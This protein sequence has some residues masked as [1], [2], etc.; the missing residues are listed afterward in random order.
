MKTAKTETH[1]DPAAQRKRKLLLIILPL[2]GAIGSL[3]LYLHGGR[4]VETDNAYIKAQKIP[5]SASVSGNVIEVAVNENDP[6][7]AGQLLFRIDPAPF[8]IEVDKAEAKLAQV[9]TDLAALKIAYRAKQGEVTLAANNLAF[10]QKELKRQQG[11][12]ERHFI[13]AAKLDDARHAS[14]IATQQHAILVQDLQR[15][16]AALGG[17][18]NLPV[19]Q[20]PTYRSAQAELAQARLNL[21]DCEVRAPQTGVSSKAPKVGQFVAAGNPAMLVVSREVW[22][23]ANFTENDLTYVQPGQAVRIKVDTYPDADL[24]G[25]VES[26]APATG[27][28]YSVIPAQ[29]ATGNWIKVAQRLTVRIRLPGSS[30]VPALRTGMSSWVEIDT[31]HRRHLLGVAL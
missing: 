20:H 26:L 12:A 5:V 7:E 10:A 23:E 8:A 15:M 4:Y 2:L 14:D 18:P 11:L 16:A 19:E 13:P 25:T 27:A 30:A 29:N 6:V 28:E 1:N 31:G 24:R 9:R 3:A 22:I 17:D 21:K